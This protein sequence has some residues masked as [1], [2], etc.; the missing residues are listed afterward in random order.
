MK[1]WKTT[2]VGWITATV[3]IGYKVITHQ[4]ITITDISIAGGAIGIGTA[5]KD[6]NVTGGSIQQ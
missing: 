3:L 1:S 6:G 2:L 4:P 5:A